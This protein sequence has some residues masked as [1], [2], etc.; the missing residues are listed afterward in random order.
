MAEAQIIRAIDV[1]MRLDA[2]GYPS[3]VVNDRVLHDSIFTIL[4]T[5]PGERV[6]QPAFGCWAKRLIFGNLN[7]ATAIRVR[8]EMLRAIATWEPRVTVLGIEITYDEKRAKIEASVSWS[9]SGK[10][11]ST[12]VLMEV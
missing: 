2:T 9:S 6:F 1:P 8:G 12:S 11:A 3:P 5:T 10:E 7:R 4:S